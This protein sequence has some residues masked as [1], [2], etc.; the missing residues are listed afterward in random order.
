M[1][2][3]HF[4]LPALL[5]I[6]LVAPSAQGIG[7]IVVNHDEVTLNDGVFALGTSDAAQFALNLATFFV[8]T[9]S[10][11]NFLV[12]EQFGSLN[13][14]SLA[15]TMTSAGHLWTINPGI[16]FDLPTLSAFDAIFFARNQDGPPVNF[17]VLT[18]YVN[19]G[20]SVYIAGGATT[21]SGEASFWNSFLNSFGLQFANVTNTISGL[22]PVTGTH[23]ILSGVND[24]FYSQGRTIS[25]TG[26]NLDAQLVEVLSG[27][28]LI[29]VVEPP[30]LSPAFACV[31][32]EPPMNDRGMSRRM[33]NFG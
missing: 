13:G 24:L 29:A 18:A 16:T 4:T 22:I 6:L 20:G 10:T 31:G 8:G 1:N 23:P 30:V 17:A 15:T 7:K 32:F 28:G 21:C 27:Q 19:N 12:Y 9:A 14:G 26:T 3:R 5:L 11:G 2:F 25:L 33:L